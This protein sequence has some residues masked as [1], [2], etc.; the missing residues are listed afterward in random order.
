M[1]D[2]IVHITEQFEVNTGVKQGDLLSALL[3]SIVID[4]IMSELEMRGNISK[5]LRQITAYA[6]NILVMART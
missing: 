6:N 5:R 4:V 1:H 2:P 3:F